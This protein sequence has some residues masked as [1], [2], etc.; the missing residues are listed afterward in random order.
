MLKDGIARRIEGFVRN[1]CFSL[2]GPRGT[3]SVAHM[4]LVQYLVVL[5]MLGLGWLKERGVELLSPVAAAAAASP[6][7]AFS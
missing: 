1:R 3:Y 2:A 4:A 7:L 5:F 6:S